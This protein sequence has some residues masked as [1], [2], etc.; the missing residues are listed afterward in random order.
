MRICIQ[1]FVL[2]QLKKITEWHIKPAPQPNPQ[3]EIQ[4]SENHFKEQ[5]ELMS[6]A[7]QNVIE[8]N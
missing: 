6:R 3:V 4:R 7:E 1:I 5:K 2:C 8:A